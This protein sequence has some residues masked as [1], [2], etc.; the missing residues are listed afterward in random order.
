MVHLYKELQPADHFEIS[1]P[2]FLSAHERQLITLFYQPLTGLESISLYYTLWAEGENQSTSTFNHYHLM[3]LL[4][5]PIG[6]LFEAR[7]SL[8]AIGLL[9]TYRKDTVDGRFFVYELIRPLDAQSFFQDPLLSMFLFSKIGEQTYRNLQ[10]RFLKHTKLDSYTEVSRTFVDVYKPVNTNVPKELT[11]IGESKKQDVPFYY[12]QFDFNLLFSGLSEQ[13]VPSSAIT[14]E[15][16]E[17][18]AKLAFLYQ[19]SPLDMQKVVILALDEH[20]KITDER[21]K[22]AALEYYQLTISKDLPMIDKTFEKQKPVNEKKHSKEQE[23]INYYETTSPIDHLRNLNNG[24]EPTSFIRELIENLFIKH[25]M[26]PGVVNVLI[27]YVMLQSD[28]K[29]PKNFVET[30][31]DHWNRKNIQTAKEAMEFARLEH[32]KYNKKPPQLTEVLDK[33]KSPYDSY[34]VYE[35]LCYLND[36]KE[37]FDYIVK[38]AESLV[39]FHGLPI[40]VVNVLME[41]AIEQTNGKVNKKFVETIASN[42][43]TLNIQTSEEALDHI[44]KTKEEKQTKKESLFNA[45]ITKDNIQ[46]FIAISDELDDD[47]KYYELTP[48]YQFLKNYYNGNEPFPMTVKLAEDLVVVYGLPVGVVNVLTEYVLTTHNGQFPK[49]LVDTIASNWRQLGINSAQSAIDYVLQQNEAKEMHKKLGY[50]PKITPESIAKVETVRA[51]WQGYASLTPYEFLKYLNKGMEP[52]SSHVR[53]AES[54]V[55]KFGLSVGVT[56]VLIEYVHTLKSGQLPKK[57]VEVIANDW[58]NKQI[59]TV[60]QAKNNIESQ[61]KAN[62]FRE[63]VGYI[64][65]ITEDKLTSLNNERQMDASYAKYENV[66]PYQFLKNINNGIEP[67]GQHVRLAESLV[68]RFELP[69]G[70]AN[71]LV[72]YVLEVNDGKLPTKFTETIAADWRYRGIV[73]TS[74]AFEIAK[75]S[76]ESRRQ[77]QKEK[78]LNPYGTKQ[79]MPIPKWFNDRNKSAEEFKEEHDDQI[80]FEKERQRILEKLGNKN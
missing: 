13:L 61:E 74:Q 60:E 7:I 5:M 78:E 37:P 43:M 32:D 22:K 9:R 23:L 20:L 39:N 72:E 33:E 1:I 69:V 68:N 70:V 75:E 57:Y 4:D 49:R 58:R 59:Q 66:T 41:Y 36:G 35:F 44:Q 30:I 63:K 53:L 31:A 65:T 24:K 45:R 15:V 77:R 14:P 51:E 64:P 8:E 16:R 56:N 67:Y 28:K 27:D 55:L 62:E 21:L 19:L 29:L 42:W 73:T 10:K 76:V 48:P 26:N 25:G 3:N 79:V 50:I 40:S 80:D 34:N 2:H 47:Y 38:I 17:S 12:Q 71:V 54:L 18:I 46:Q 6:K 11:Q 52:L